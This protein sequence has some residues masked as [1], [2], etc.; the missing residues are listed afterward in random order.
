MTSL[1]VSTVH[2][3]MSLQRGAPPPMHVRAPLH[4][5]VVVQNIPSSQLVPLGASGLLHAPAV[6]TSV[7]QTTPS[8][9]L[10]QTAPRTPQYDA[11]VPP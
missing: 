10:V 3:V 4:V 5:S 1:H 2:A 9:Q 6:H 8:T 11:V 7:E